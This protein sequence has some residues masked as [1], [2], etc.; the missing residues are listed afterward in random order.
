MLSPPQNDAA[1]EAQLLAAV[2]AGDREAFRQ[3]Y[4]RYSA[5]L[6]SLAI[7]LVGDAGTAEEVLQDTFVKLWKH[8]AAYDARK[9]RPF[10]WAVTILRRTCIDQL[11]KQRR[12]PPGAALPEDDNATEEFFTRETTRQT[13]EVNETTER[14]HAALTTL[15]APQRAAVELALFS[16]LT[17]AEIAA[18]LAQPIGSIKTWIRRGLLELRATLNEST[19]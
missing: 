5:P 7:R 19:P 9:S 16:T 1:E 12:H 2:A 6:F 14:L 4:A 3:L 11:R 13:T 8:S 10:T 15:S 18:R 17:Q